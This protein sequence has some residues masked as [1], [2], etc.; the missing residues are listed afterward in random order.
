[1]TLPTFDE[2]MATSREGVAF[3]N[4]TEAECWMENYCGRCVNDAELRR[5][6]GPGCA[7]VLVAY[8]DRFPAEWTPDKPGHLGQQWRCMYFRSEEDGGDPE[9]KPI[10]DPPG[11]LTLAPREPFERPARMLA[12]LGTPQP[13]E[14]A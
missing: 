2:A 4:G 11:Q 7:L 3:S 6:D 13:A 1:M 14:V 5:G 10:P 9:P 8:E 12:P